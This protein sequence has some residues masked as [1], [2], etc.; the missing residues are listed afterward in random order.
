VKNVRRVGTT[1]VAALT[2]AAAMAVPSTAQAAPPLENIHYEFTD[3]S[4][5]DDCGFTIESQV[6]G[7]G[8]FM[9]RE[10]E[11]SDGQAFL[12]HDNYRYREVLTNPATGAWFVITGHALFKEMIGRQIDGDIWEFTAHEAGQPFVVEDSDGNVVL[13]DRGR[14]TFRAVFD[15]LGDGEPGGEFIEQ[16]LTSISGPHPGFF[17]DFCEI[18]TEL[19]G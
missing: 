7:S 9:V 3:S 13:R 10:I 4:S 14:L 12:G 8:H 5:F 1:G 19:I 15:T 17:A 6:A 18:A 11:G 2:V 16:E